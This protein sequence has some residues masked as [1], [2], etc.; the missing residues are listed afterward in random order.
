MVGGRV[1]ARKLGA[2]AARL[3]DRW[4]ARE[5]GLSRHRGKEHPGDDFGDEMSVG[6]LHRSPPPVKATLL[7]SP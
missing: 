3:G 1:Q 6:R 4:D 7:L 2:S 5:P